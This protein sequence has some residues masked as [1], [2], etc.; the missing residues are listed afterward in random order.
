MPQPKQFFKHLS[1]ARS[2]LHMDF[3]RDT[4]QD[5]RCSLWNH[6]DTAT[7]F[8]PGAPSSML[9]H[10]DAERKHLATAISTLDLFQGLEDFSYL[11]FFILTS[12]QGCMETDYYSR[13]PLVNKTSLKL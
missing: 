6:N 1:T 5:D 13:A 4:Q 12:L 11:F 3:P 9:T 10:P 2:F 7:G 8:V